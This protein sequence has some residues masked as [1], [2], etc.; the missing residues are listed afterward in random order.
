MSIFNLPYKLLVKFDRFRKKSRKLLAP[1][2][3]VGNISSGGRGKT[4]FCIYLCKELQ[5]RSFYPVVLTRGYGRKC[6]RDVWLSDPSDQVDAGLVGDEALEIH[7]LTGAPVLVGSNRYRNA[8]A[9][10]R[11]LNSGDQSKCVF[12]LDDG[13]QHWSLKRDFDI[14]LISKC[15]LED[16]LLPFGRLRE[17]LDALKRADEVLTLGADFKKV[18]GVANPSQKESCF[19]T[20]RVYDQEYF[21]ELKKYFPAGKELPLRDHAPRE[22]INRAISRL[23]PGTTIV[24]GFKEAV[25]MI[26]L[27]N[28][29]SMLVGLKFEYRC[30]QLDYP[31]CLVTCDIRLTHEQRLWEKIDRLLKA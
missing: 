6:T 29:K 23:A 16:R 20:T 25:K 22:E 21:R 28:L 17:D 26:S 14:C 12:I 4:P 30:H 1:V 3:S 31:L 15:D 11:Q 27:E 18:V 5:K 10:L 8:E 13:F 9:F 19:L 2:I 24:L 7:L